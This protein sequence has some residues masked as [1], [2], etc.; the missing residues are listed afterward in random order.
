MIGGIGWVRGFLVV[1]CGNEMEFGMCEMEVLDVSLT[2][3]ASAFEN[4]SCRPQVV[5]LVDEV[6]VEKSSR[7]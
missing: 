7:N 5:T 4:K 2:F 6:M 3:A 1:W